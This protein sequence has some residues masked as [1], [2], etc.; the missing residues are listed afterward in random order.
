MEGGG[1][2]AGNIV[3]YFLFNNSL[4]IGWMAKLTKTKLK[5]SQFPITYIRRSGHNLRVKA[6]FTRIQDLTKMLIFELVNQTL[7]GNPFQISSNALFI[8]LRLE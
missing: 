2:L 3:H 6:M 4:H 7:K 1:A 5:K 8:M